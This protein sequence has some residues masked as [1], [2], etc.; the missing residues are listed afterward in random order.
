MRT[1]EFRDVKDGDA[2]PVEMSAATP[3]GGARMMRHVCPSLTEEEAIL[4]D[5]EARRRFLDVSVPRIKAL[6]REMFER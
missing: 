2:I 6:L 4:A 3:E 1:L 5:A